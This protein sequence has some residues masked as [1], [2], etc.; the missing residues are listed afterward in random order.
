MK[1]IINVE[2]GEIIERELTDDEIAQQQMDE[3]DALAKLEEIAEQEAE[4]NAQKLAILERLGLSED[5][6]KLILG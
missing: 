6:A 1:Q 4:R 3:A 2:T 5:E